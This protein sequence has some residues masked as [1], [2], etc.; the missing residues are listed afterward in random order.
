MRIRHRR[1]TTLLAAATL[2]LSGIGAGAATAATT[3]TITGTI[4]DEVTGE[5]LA[6]CVTA[7]TADDGA[8]G[9]VQACAGDDGHYS[10][11]VTAGRA[12][13]VEFSAWDHV[14]E[15][16][17]GVD[18]PNLATHVTA[19]GVADASLQPNQTATGLVRYPDGVGI[20]GVQVHFY[21]PDGAQSWAT[22]ETDSE[23]AWSVPLLSG[24]Y[25]V[26]YWLPE[27]D[28]LYSNGKTTRPAKPSLTVKLGKTPSPQTVTF[29]R[30]ATLVAH[31]VDQAAQPLAGACVEAGA[32]R[33]CSGNDGTATLTGLPSGSL[34][35]VASTEDASRG[36]VQ[37][38]VAAKRGATRELTLRLAPS[39][40][41]QGTIVGESGKA[42]SKVCLRLE[43]AVGDPLPPYL[44]KQQVTCSDST[45]RWSV[46]GVPSGRY[47]VWV[48]GD[49]THPYVYAP[50]VALAK[51]ATVVTAQ[52]GR[53]VQTGVTT[54]GVGGS[55]SGVITSPA[56]KPVAD[57]WVVLNGD[58]PG[59]IGDGGAG[60]YTARTDAK[61]VYTIT[62]VPQ[63]SV[64]V[65]AYLR[66]QPYA[67]TWSGGTTDSVSAQ[68]VQVAWGKTATANITFL[69]EVP[70]TVT[71]ANAPK[72]A[73]VELDLISAG[74]NPAGYSGEVSAE[75]PTT[76]ISG[77]GAGKVRLRVQ[78]ALPNVPDTK[79]PTFWYVDATSAE[80]ATPVTLVAGQ[81]AQLTVTLP[82]W[83][84]G[85]K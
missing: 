59:R 76:T 31:L 30:P 9:Y 42:R 41:V 27:G 6:G 51:D 56:G 23:G 21:R 43:S 60:I 4:T 79:F 3:S 52:A 33:A 34:T 2:T 17:D 69:P 20:P 14:D 7:T 57:A 11:K 38:V 68:K 73:Y 46:K 72:G 18:D 80:T 83:A 58:N 39:A 81:P 22:A 1:G 5:P 54:A 63:W 66:S 25:F 74:G 78:V 85:N 37:K 48:Y 32:E 55:V 16:F 75:R 24:S 84:L 49:D 70:L 77:L 36:A 45:G 8:W 19:P 15:Y 53:T 65:M 47:Q 10:V 26:Q 12:Y 13:Q 71:V 40:V 44:D 82:A 64:P 29:G 50:G 28:M 62:N 61:G 67:F 35:L